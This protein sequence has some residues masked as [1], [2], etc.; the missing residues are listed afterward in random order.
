[1]DTFT[2]RAMPKISIDP[3]IEI[4][5]SHSGLP[6]EHYLPLCRTGRNNLLGLAAAQK[7]LQDLGDV[8]IHVEVIKIYFYWNV[9]HGSRQRICADIVLVEPGTNN[10]KRVEAH[11]GIYLECPE[12]SRGN[13]VGHEKAIGMLSSNLM[14]AIRW[15]ILDLQ[16]VRSENAAA[17]NKFDRLL[18]G[19]PPRSMYKRKEACSVTD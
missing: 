4:L 19:V 14:K 6:Q 10:K 8:A 5:D 17:L 1:M 12:E 3:G 16:R 13:N 9:N 7:I 2:L 18:S 15:Q 11:S